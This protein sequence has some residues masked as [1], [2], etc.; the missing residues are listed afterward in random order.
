VFLQKSAH[1]RENKGFE[2]RTLKKEREE[3]SALHQTTT[4]TPGVL[5]RY[6]NKGVA[7]E[8]FHIDMKTK[9]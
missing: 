6:Q 2:Y 9:G 5:Y 8:G 7:G 3:R 4:P 1:A